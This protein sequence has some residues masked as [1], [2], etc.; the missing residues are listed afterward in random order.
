M[1][2]NVKIYEAQRRK[3]FLLIYFEMIGELFTAKSL[4]VRLFKRDFSA[5]YRQSFLGVLW[6]VIAPVFS[7]SIFWMLNKSGVINA[8]NLRIPYVVYALY[9]ITVW[10]LFTGIVNNLNGSINTAAGFITKINFPRVAIVFSPFHA[11]TE[12]L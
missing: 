7:V 1:S 11:L 4:G 6:V 12:F 5:K 2:S 10:N 3:F 8:G 9:G